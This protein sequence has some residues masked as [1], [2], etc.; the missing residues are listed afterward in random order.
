MSKPVIGGIGGIGAQATFD[1]CQT[2]LGLIPA[3]TNSDYPRML[4]D[5]NPQFP[6]INKAL[7]GQGP[8]PAK[9]LAASAAQLE[10]AGADVLVLICNGAHAYAESIRAAVDIPLVSMIDA[11]VADAADAVPPGAP[12][13]VLATDGV[14]KSGIFEQ[15]LTATGR[16]PLTLEASK[17]A[18][19]MHALGIEERRE[20]PTQARAVMQ[21]CVDL[22][23]EQGAKALIGGCTEIKP[24]IEAERLPVAMIDPLQALAQRVAC[25]LA[26]D[27]ENT[28]GQSTHGR[29]EYRKDRL[30]A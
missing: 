10:R 25:L 3:K 28:H 23:I 6:D 13:G 2:L 27:R 5:C 22:L 30:L 29:L 9:A 12:I 11:A 1:F 16:K 8:S 21:A 20:R 4:I 19:F 26:N 7:L 15:A 14:L 24:L 18:E 17:L